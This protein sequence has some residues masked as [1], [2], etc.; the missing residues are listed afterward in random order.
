MLKRW[1]EIST[2]VGCANNCIYCPQSILINKYCKEEGNKETIMSL[3]T[4]K[5]ALNNIPKDVQIDF[6]GMSEPF[7]NPSTIDMILEAY[8]QGHEILLYTTFRGLDL[9]GFNKIKHIPFE[10]FCVHLP[11]K[12]FYMKYS[13]NEEFFEI[14]EEFV[15][16]DIPNKSY[17]VLG[18]IH[19]RI[20]DY[21]N[22]KNITHLQAVGRS[23]N[24][25]IN[26]FPE[27]LIRHEINPNKFL[28][29]RVMCSRSI[30]N[31]K[32]KNDIVPENTIM[33]PNGNVLLCCMDYGMKH[34]LGNILEGTYENIVLQ[35]PAMGKIIRS[36]LDVNDRSILCKTCEHAIEYSRWKVFVF[37]YFGIY[38]ARSLRYYILHRDIFYKDNSSYKRYTFLA[39]MGFDLFKIKIKNYIFRLGQD[40]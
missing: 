15:N 24:L 5:K 34:K 27:N 9:E 18:K 14:L 39:F 26:T 37:K 16:S 1:I 28:N 22:V 35:S 6:A 29:K 38:P 11:D 31:N 8:N 32:L 12:D 20:L 40:Y 19:P 4:F 3:E 30:A 33:L 17:V 7:Q 21:V 10:E 25:D 36:M 23:F 2:N 13:L